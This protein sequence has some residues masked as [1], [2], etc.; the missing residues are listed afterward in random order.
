[1][2]ECAEVLIERCA[3]C[4]AT[5]LRRFQISGGK[6][7]PRYGQCKTCGSRELEEISKADVQI[8]HD[9]AKLIKETEKLEQKIAKVNRDI[10]RA[11]QEE[12]QLDKRLAQ[13]EE[14]LAKRLAQVALENERVN[15]A[16]ALV[17]K[18]IAQV[19]KALEQIRIDL[20]D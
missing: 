18:A 6:N 11:L 13:E 1:M 14:Q 20:K 4:K 16:I 19:D 10:E 7:I 3:I 9:I 12:E 5:D 8:E 15:S 2:N 17:D